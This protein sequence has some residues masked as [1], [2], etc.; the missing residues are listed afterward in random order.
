MKLIFILLT[1]ASLLWV[2]IQAI[3]PVHSGKHERAEVLRK[4]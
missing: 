2:A 1:T 3:D 4:V